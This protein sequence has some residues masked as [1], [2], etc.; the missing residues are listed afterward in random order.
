MKSTPLLLAGVAV[1]F[2]FVAGYFNIGVE[3][4]LYAGA[5]AAAWLGP[6]LIGVPAIVAVPLM[7]IVGFAGGML[8]A[9]PPAWLKARLNVDEVVTTLL[10][11][12]VIVFQLHVSHLQRKRSLG[13]RASQQ[14]RR[15]RQRRASTDDDSANVRASTRLVVDDAHIAS[16]QVPV[17]ARMMPGMAQ[18]IRQQLR[19]DKVRIR[20]AVYTMAVIVTTHL[21]CNSLHLAIA[22]ERARLLV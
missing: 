8:W 22:G 16:A 19:E 4:Q 17:L 1:A 20:S 7:L 10:L 9:L 15:L 6:Q 18:R 5:I 14:A 11:N 13:G 2:A 21:V 12:S 3:G